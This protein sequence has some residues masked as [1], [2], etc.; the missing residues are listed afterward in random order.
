MDREYIEKTACEFFGIDADDLR[1]DS[2][3]QPLAKYRFMVW[4]ALRERTKL[5]PW[6]ITSM[7]NRDSSTI[8][9]GIKQ[10]RD[11][12]ALNK[13]YI[14]FESYFVDNLGKAVDKPV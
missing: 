9:H 8:R 5:K 14:A 12:E 2:R 6:M 3:R 11:I 7:Y 10:S 4:R 13:D 1:S